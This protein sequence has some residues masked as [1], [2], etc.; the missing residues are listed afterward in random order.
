MNGKKIDPIRPTDDEAR[1]LAKKLLAGSTFASIGV[2]EPETGYP[3]VSRI[4]FGRDGTGR[5]V[6]LASE[7]SFH[8]KALMLD[9]RATM[10]VGEPPAKGDPLA[11]PRVTL[12]GDVTR[13]DRSSP[14]RDALRG[15]WL[16]RHPKAQLYIDFGDFHFF[17]M[18]VKRANLNGG[19]GKAFVLSPADLGIA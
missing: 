7:L 1:A 14:E 16:E 6:F 15:P 5:P 3:L 18:E 9:P 10:L 4:A 11:F 12:I 2:I 19:F 13:I 8:S 17:R